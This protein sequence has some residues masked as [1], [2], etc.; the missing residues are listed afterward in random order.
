MFSGGAI[1]DLGLLA[2]PAIA[3]DTATDKQPI[4]RVEITGS[5]IKR[6]AKEGALPV[7]VLTSADIK[8]SGATSAT[9]LIQM[10][11]SMQGFVPAS[12]SVNGGGAGVTTAAL[13]SLPSKYTLVLLDG[14]RL[15]PSLLGTGQG[16]GY[17]VNIES[18]PLEAVERVEILGDGASALYG[19]DAIA[20]V[21]NFILKKNMTKG[22]AYAT[23]GQPR[24]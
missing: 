20:G 14:Q 13:H 16:G 17:A 5:A 22:E 19:S 2:L 21:V 11:P 18:I 9:D 1:A 23:Y 4:Q 24:K 10:L 12:S 6:I 8:Q 3:Q 7:Q 15:A